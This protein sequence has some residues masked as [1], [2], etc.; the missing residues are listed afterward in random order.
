MANGPAN[1]KKGN[2]NIKD[3]KKLIDLMRKAELTEVDIEQEGLKIK[4]RK[5]S[6]PQVAVAAAAPPQPAA[7]VAAPVPAAP[8]A[9]LAAPVQAPEVPAAGRT[10][11]TIT[12]PMVGTF[13]SASTP[14]TPPFI[15]E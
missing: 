15:Q 9:P 11:L 14:D 13:Y 12:A 10:G 6:E 1:P 2:V 4:L 3:L 5:G 8:P 7:P